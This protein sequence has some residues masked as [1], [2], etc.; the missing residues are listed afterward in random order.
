MDRRI[1]T[2]DINS[3]ILLRAHD[4]QARTNIRS[5]PLRAEHAT[6]RQVRWPVRLQDH[7]HADERSSFP[8]HGCSA[9][10]KIDFS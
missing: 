4:S 1:P 6:P 7:D 8:H 2:I 3:W 10:V 9:R 5:C